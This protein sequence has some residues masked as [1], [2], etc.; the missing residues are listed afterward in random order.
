MPAMTT[1]IAPTPF[2][3][4]EI[5]AIRGE[6]DWSAE[7]GVPAHITLL[8]PFLDPDAITSRVLDRLE[9]AVAE[10]RAIPITFERLELVGDVACL[11]PASGSRIA[12]LQAALHA[13]WPHL[14]ARELQHVTVARSLSMEDFDRI[15]RRVAPFLP[16]SGVVDEILLVASRDEHA[17]ARTIRT[18]RLR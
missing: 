1:I 14:Q 7:L 15:A 16:T 17:P 10:H 6:H 5:E 2:V 8:G 13:T 9:S 3:G 4:A 18:L 11:L 12:A